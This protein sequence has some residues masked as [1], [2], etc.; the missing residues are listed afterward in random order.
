[1]WYVILIILFLLSTGLAFFVAYHLI[2][3]RDKNAVLHIENEAV[4][5]ENWN[6]LVD[7][8]SEKASSRELRRQLDYSHKN[9]SMVLASEKS[10]VGSSGKK[11]TI[12]ALPYDPRHR[13]PSQE[14]A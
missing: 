12:V 9:L 8:A 4:R 3:Q 5:A 6:A 11:S 13:P 14:L 10:P 1:M 2:E 7:L